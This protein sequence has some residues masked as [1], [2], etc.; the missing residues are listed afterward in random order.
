MIKKIK[1]LFDYF[2]YLKNPFEALKFKF[3]LTKTCI[4]KLKEDENYY[5]T[6]NNVSSLNEFMRLLPIIKKESRYIFLKYIE[7][8]DS[9][10]KYFNIN[11]ITFLNIYNSDFIKTH[12][13][14]YYSHLMEFFTSDVLEN[15]NYSNRHVVDIGGNIGDTALFFANEGAKVISFEPVKH[16]YD[17]AV[18]NVNLNNDLKKNIILVNKAIGG[19]RGKLSLDST[20]IIEYVDT[21]SNEMEVITINDLFEQ[22]DFTPDILKMDCEGCEFEIIE[23]NDLSMFNEI[24][25]EHHSKIVKKDYKPLVTELKKQGFEI[26]FFKSSET[27]NEFEKQGMIYAYK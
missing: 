24:L 6:L 16:L 14:N 23:N 3:G 4:I 20:S 15:I 11:G 2:K 21:D 19:K 25:F 8:I 5:A 12:P 10:D 13:H 9:D 17:L 27:I 18:E 22:F 26:K 1:Y 7:S